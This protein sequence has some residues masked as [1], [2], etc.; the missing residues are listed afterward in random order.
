MQIKNHSNICNQWQIPYTTLVSLMPFSPPRVPSVN[1]S[2]RPQQIQREHERA[3]TAYPN[4]LCLCVCARKPLGES[5]SENKMRRFPL[6]LLGFRLHLPSF[7]PSS[8][9]LSFV[10]SGRLWPPLAHLNRRRATAADP[11]LASVGHLL[12]HMC[13]SSQ[14]CTAVD[15]SPRTGHHQQQYTSDTLLT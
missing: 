6:A 14:K 13:M 10:A 1:M 12:L 3:S 8:L 15:D 5:K 7:P 4:L 2:V 11:A 9:T